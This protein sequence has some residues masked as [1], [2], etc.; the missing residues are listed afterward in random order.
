MPLIDIAGPFAV[1]IGNPQSRCP[2]C[3]TPNPIP[4][5]EVEADFKF[6]FV[7]QLRRTYTTFGLINGALRPLHDVFI[8]NMD[9]VMSLG[10]LPSALIFHCSYY[11]ERSGKDVRVRIHD[12]PELG[13]MAFAGYVTNDIH[14]DANYFARLSNNGTYMA[15][16]GVLAAMLIGCW[17]AFETLAADLW[18]VTLNNRPAL[19]VKVLESSPGRPVPIQLLQKFDFNLKNK[20]GEW[21]SR[22]SD[23]SRRDQIEKAYRKTFGADDQILMG[24]FRDNELKWLNAVRNVLVH[25]GGIADDEFQRRVQEHPSLSTVKVGEPV[26]INGELV[27][28][29][30]SAVAERSRELLLYVADWMIKNPE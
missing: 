30:F 6:P 12:G 23:L 13:A 4:T 3:G 10:M 28:S 27:S 29:S 7:S 1:F 19:G 9:R 17:T 22:G 16:E 24:I 14:S 8:R 2:A 21:L 11:L 15:I 20:M 18:V 26:P 5:T 25:K